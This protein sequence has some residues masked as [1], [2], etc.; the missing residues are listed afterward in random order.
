MPIPTDALVAQPDDSRT[1]TD[2][3]KGILSGLRDA[4]AYW[5][6][7]HNR[8]DMWANMYL[9]LDVVQM[10]KPLGVAR[11]FISN[12]PRTGFDAAQAILTRN[13]TSW[14]IPIP[15]NATDDEK[16]SIGALERTLVGL[17]WDMDELFAQ[18][19][20]PPLWKQIHFQGLLRGMIWGKFHIT[21]EALKFRDSPLVPE[22]YDSRMVHPHTDDWGLNH[23]YIEKPTTLGALVSTWPEQFKDVNLSSRN[24]NGID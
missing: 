2:M 11:R 14:S 19:L 21:T 20:A 16:R 1:R 18:R 23:V 9:L 4:K 12:E 3:M 15:V 7:L 22:I 24:M 5:Q 6:P 8:Q 17:G 13:S 10:S